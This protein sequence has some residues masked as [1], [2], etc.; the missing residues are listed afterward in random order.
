MANGGASDTELDRGWSS[1]SDSGEE[2]AAPGYAASVTERVTAS[3]TAAVRDAGLGPRGCTAPRPLLEQLSASATSALAEAQHSAEG[4]LETVQA[5]PERLRALTSPPP[6]AA[7]PAGVAPPKRH[8]RR[9]QPDAGSSL[10]PLAR[11]GYQPGAL[12]VVRREPDAAE[13]GRSPSFAARGLTLDS[14]ARSQSFTGVPRA[15]ERRSGA[16]RSQVAPSVAGSLPLSPAALQALAV[17]EGMRMRAA[18]LSDLE[19]LQVRSPA[20]TALKERA[21]G[22]SEPPSSTAGDVLQGAA[23]ALASLLLPQLCAS[24]PGRLALCTPGELAARGAYGSAIQCAALALNVITSA[25]LLATWAV[26]GARDAWLARVCD[27]DRHAAWDA[28]SSQLRAPQHA[29]FALRLDAVNGRAVA[30]CTA[31][32]ALIV[33]NAAL[34]LAS[35]TQGHASAADASSPTLNAPVLF[36]LALALTLPVF[37]RVALAR[38]AAAESLDVRLALPAWQ[39]HGLVSLNVID[40]VAAEAEAAAAADVAARKAAAPVWGE[41]P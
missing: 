40:G 21:A 7:S 36:P 8:H 17:A 25:A 1:G 6:V 4:V 18:G 2:A 13:P 26:V 33:V 22:F 9:K 5:L 35:A 31:T 3:L 23:C 28:L 34:S 24:A 29:A 38:A 14:F 32:L 19:R 27:E 11:L 12:R 20:V 37:R 10:P 30:V 15:E 41:E 16:A 39:G